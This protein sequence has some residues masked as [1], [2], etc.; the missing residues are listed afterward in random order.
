MVHLYPGEITLLIAGVW[1]AK[2]EDVKES[3]VI[4]V[5]TDG[6]SFTVTPLSTPIVPVTD[7]MLK[8]GSLLDTCYVCRMGNTDTIHVRC[9][10]TSFLYD[11][12]NNSWRYAAELV[13]LEWA[14]DDYPAITFT[15]GCLTVGSWEPTVRFTDVEFKQDIIGEGPVDNLYYHA[16]TR[17]TEHEFVVT[18]GYGDR[19][20]QYVTITYS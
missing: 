10:N 3:E 8:E 18:G 5:S 14:G 7:E 13:Q 11:I 2:F 17:I 19:Y 16:L 9:D 4:T 15:D 20:E 6:D 12:N 1:K